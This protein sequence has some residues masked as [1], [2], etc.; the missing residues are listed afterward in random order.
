MDKHP[1]FNRIDVAF[2]GTHNRNHLVKKDEL[3]DYVRRWKEQN[4]KPYVDC[5]RTYWLY[6]D[7]MLEHF[8]KKKSVSQYEGY[9]YSE[10]L[11]IDV[12]SSDLI[13]SLQNTKAI[14]H[15]LEKNYDVDL[16]VIRIYFSGSKGFHLE[17]PSGLFG[18]EAS[19]FLNEIFKAIVFRLLADVC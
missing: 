14:L 15:H 13:Q 9:V 17:L 6:P 19:Q 11:P 1:D 7:A 5:Y 16:K 3:A 2:G 4:K 18:F 10:F 8:E 12:D